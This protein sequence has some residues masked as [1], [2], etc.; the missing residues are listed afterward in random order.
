MHNRHGKKRR[1]V[2]KQHALIFVSLHTRQNV[3]KTH[4]VFNPGGLTCGANWALPITPE[5][6]SPFKFTGKIYV[7]TVG[8]SGDLIENSKAELRL[9]MARQ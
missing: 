7:G 2:V 9:V 4:V 3:G 5:Y 1:R 6:A 8:V